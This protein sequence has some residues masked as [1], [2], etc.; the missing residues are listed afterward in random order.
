MLGRMN[1]ARLPESRRL[2][3]IA[4]SVELTAAGPL[5]A[6]GLLAAAGTVCFLLVALP[7]GLV[8]DRVA[9]RR[10]MII[11][12]AARML[13]LGSVAVS[14]AFGVLTMVQLFA[15]ALHRAGDRLLRRGVPELRAVAD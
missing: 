3:G 12:D 7:A 14:A 13:T 9:R 6:A 1:I 11:C 15:V 2:A 8:V 5:A 4:I 10:L